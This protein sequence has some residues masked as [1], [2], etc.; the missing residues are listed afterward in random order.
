MKLLFSYS[1]RLFS[2]LACCYLF[3]PVAV[4]GQNPYR[5]AANHYRL[6]M[7]NQ[8]IRATRVTYAPGESA[9]VHDHPKGG[10][11]I[12][13]YMT[14]AGVMRFRHVEDDLPAHIAERPPVKAGSL[15]LAN[16]TAES[17]SVEYLGNT[18]SEYIIIELR[19]SEHFA[20]KRLPPV[21]LDPAKSISQV[22]FEDEQ[23]RVVR[24]SCAAGERCPES[25][26]PHDPAVVTVLTGPERGAVKWAPERLAGPMQQIRF[27]LKSLPGGNPAT[28]KVTSPK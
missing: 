14:D 16:G 17:H 26:H 4:R 1:A 15:R 25:G 7:E 2:L 5:V 22:Q 8:W 6:I 19:T 10:A 28:H 20:Y 24:V 9:P 21:A 3:F 11:I 27:E 23:I 18:P 12:Y 13:V